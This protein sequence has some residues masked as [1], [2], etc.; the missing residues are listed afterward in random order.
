MKMAETG[1]YGA[2]GVYILWCCDS[3][4]ASQ[5]LPKMR[6]AA[7]RFIGNATFARIL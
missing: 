1:S 4:P 2:V 5:R 3:G 7:D 6:A